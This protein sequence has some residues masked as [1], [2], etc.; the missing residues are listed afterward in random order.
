MARQG[1]GRKP[2]VISGAVFE[3]ELERTMWAWDRWLELHLEA[4]PQL[5]PEIVKELKAI[6]KKIAKVDE[7][8]LN[9]RPRNS[10]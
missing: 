9:R 7:L 5:R 1:G 10:L 2:A 8:L 3:G 4:N 6:K